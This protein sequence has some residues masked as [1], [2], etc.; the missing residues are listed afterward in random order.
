MSTWGWIVVGVVAVLLLLALG[1]A[2]AN[3][4][5]RRRQ[6]PELRAHLDELNR[7]LA[8]AHAA[9][10]GWER[11]AL[12]AAARRAVSERRPSAEIRDLELIHVVDRPGTEE[13]KAVFR[14][15]VAD[16]GAPARQATLTLGRRDGHWVGERL[17]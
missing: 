10:R 17:E 8:V 5:R 3:L 1:G 11:R 9:D 15:T 12:E 16:R 13:D 7:Q 14:V 6:E 2:V 4:R